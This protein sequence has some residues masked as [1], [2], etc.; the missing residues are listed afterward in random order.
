[1]PAS[2]E[3]IG[4]YVFSNCVSLSEVLFEEGSAL[5]DIRDYAFAGCGLQAM[6]VPKRVKNIGIGAV[7]ACKELHHVILSDELVAISRAMFRNDIMLQSI[8]IPRSVEVIESGAFSHC[9][10]LACVEFESGSRLETVKSSAFEACSFPSI[11]FPASLKHLQRTALSPNMNLVHTD[12]SECCQFQNEFQPFCD[13]AF[14]SYHHDALRNM[15]L[16]VAMV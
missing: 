6:V 4:S 7:S 3:V 16:T 2:V 15:R 1:M 9:L 5:V 8:I 14:I 13:T 12:L 11:E 10:R